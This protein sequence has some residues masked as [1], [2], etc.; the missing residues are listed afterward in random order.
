ML[1]FRGGGWIEHSGKSMNLGGA[2]MSDIC[3]LNR[4]RI[5]TEMFIMAS[6]IVSLNIQTIFIFLSNRHHILLVSRGTNTFVINVLWRNLFFTD[7]GQFIK[8][9]VSK[10]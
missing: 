5:S 6:S 3:K 1:I 4:S 9:L 7:L 8:G 2:G 10:T